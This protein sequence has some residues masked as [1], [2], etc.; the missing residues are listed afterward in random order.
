VKASKIKKKNILNLNK[1][2]KKRSY[3]SAFSN[4]LLGNYEINRGKIFIDGFD[5]SKLDTCILR[6]NIS[7]IPQF[8]LFFSGTVLSNIDPHKKFKKI[9]KNFLN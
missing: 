6:K 9:K 8:A 2:K 3:K 4:L 1:L 7:Y 5:I